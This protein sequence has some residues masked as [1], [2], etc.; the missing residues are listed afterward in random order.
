[1]LPL[2][3]LVR[4][5]RRQR[6]LLDLTQ[7]DLAK[8]AGTSQ[9]LIAKLERGR[10]SPG[11]ETVR[12]IVEALDGLR[13]AEEST[14]ADL[15]QDGPLWADPD[16]PL[17]DA[18]ARMKEHGFSQLPVLQGGVPVGALS[19]SAILGRIE[20][21]ADLDALK[22]QPVR[23][24]MAGS[25]PTVARETRRHSLLELLR[26]HEAVLVMDGARMVGVVTKS[27]LW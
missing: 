21:G 20:R 11:Y 6:R 19:E 16:E 26:E 2:D 10:I 9:S 13:M 17:G 14:A 12:R 1:M 18:L 8:A 27:D 24:F 3:E 22:R 15:M 23:M 7:G 4:H 25:F 5:I